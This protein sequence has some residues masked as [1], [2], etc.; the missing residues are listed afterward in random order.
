MDGLRNDGGVEWMDVEWTSICGPRTSGRGM[1]ENPGGDTS[2]PYGYGNRGVMYI[3]LER[4][5]P[6]YSVLNSQFI[7]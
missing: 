7:Q 2:M 6:T 4:R 3:N 5:T 1:D